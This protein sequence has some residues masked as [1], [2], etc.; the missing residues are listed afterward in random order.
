MNRN[1]APMRAARG[2]NVVVGHYFP[3]MVR[4]AIAD[5]RRTLAH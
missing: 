2:D 4:Q 5:A 3:Q 1:C